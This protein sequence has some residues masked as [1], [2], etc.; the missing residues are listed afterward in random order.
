MDK[1]E[2]IHHVTQSFEDEEGRTHSAIALKIIGD[3]LWTVWQCEPGDKYIVEFILV[4]TGKTEGWIS[5]RRTENTPPEGFTCPINFLQQAPQ[6]CKTWRS[7]VIDRVEG[8]NKI[9]KRIKTLFEERGDR[10]VRVTLEPD[11]GFSLFIHHL[12][13]L[14]LH[15]LEGRYDQNGRRYTVPCKFVSNIFYLER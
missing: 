12:D 14:S 1:K 4:K 13:I 2:L 5:E 9:K 15:P 10:T 7:G 11:P 6:L 3:T 8:M